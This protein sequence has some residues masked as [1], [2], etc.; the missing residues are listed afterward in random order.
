MRVARE[1]LAR[2]RPVVGPD[3]SVDEVVEIFDDEIAR[4]SQLL[5]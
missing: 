3:V 1:T 4:L 5:A 2:Q